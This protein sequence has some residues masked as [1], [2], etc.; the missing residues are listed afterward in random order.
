LFQTRGAV[1]DERLR[2]FVEGMAGATRLKILSIVE[3]A[4]DV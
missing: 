4:Q 3:T 1:S 2:T